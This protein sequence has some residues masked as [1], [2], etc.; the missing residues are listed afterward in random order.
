MWVRAPVR[1]T[2]I[3]TVRAIL[4]ARERRERDVV[5]GFWRCVEDIEHVDA[6]VWTTFE[7]VC[8]S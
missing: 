8:G 7:P 2:C 1:P 3:Q 4:V 6:F 5:S